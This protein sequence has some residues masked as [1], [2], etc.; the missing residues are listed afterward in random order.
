ML[1]L[2]S[3]G[4]TPL[5]GSLDVPWQIT[6]PRQSRGVAHPCRESLAPISVPGDAGAAVPG[7]LGL[8]SL[9]MLDPM[10][11]E[12]CSCTQ[13]DPA[14]RLPEVLAQREDLHSHHLHK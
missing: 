8:L 2:L 11:L 14:S 6:L 1:L 5:N 7:M 9:G 12:L 10:S 13:R 4:F 3:I